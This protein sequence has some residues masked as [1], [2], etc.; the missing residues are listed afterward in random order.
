MC[1]APEKQL[2]AVFFQRKIEKCFLGEM[3]RVPFCARSAVDHDQVALIVG[4]GVEG[5]AKRC[6]PT[7][8]IIAAKCPFSANVPL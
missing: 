5:R 1:A 3:H 2:I 4:K 8:I 6:K 7:A